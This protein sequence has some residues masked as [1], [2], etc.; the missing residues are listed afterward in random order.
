MYEVVPTQEKE[1]KTLIIIVVQY[2]INIR[3]SKWF[4]LLG[5]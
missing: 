2:G 5:N 4:L 3:Y 1:Y